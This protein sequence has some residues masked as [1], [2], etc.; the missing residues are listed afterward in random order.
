MPYSEV[1]AGLINPSS[2]S[3]ACLRLM[4]AF[5]M[6]Y[7]VSRYCT[8][9][10]IRTGECGSVLEDRFP[11][12]TQSL[13]WPLEALCMTVCRNAPRDASDDLTP[14]PPLW[15][16]LSPSTNND[17]FFAPVSRQR[18]NFMSLCGERFDSW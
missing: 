8:I 13:G 15:V 7:D 14:E 4:T 16:D 18:Y 6:W 10:M 9:R 5:A 1:M 12:V 11:T 3:P 17:S 2:R